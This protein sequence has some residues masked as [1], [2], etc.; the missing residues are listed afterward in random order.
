MATQ[1]P[2]SR[3]R[4]QT[5]EVELEA[6]A[7][8]HPHSSFSYIVSGELEKARGCGAVVLEPNLFG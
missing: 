5:Q 3:V 8:P 7:L 2:G 1:S 4:T 6:Q